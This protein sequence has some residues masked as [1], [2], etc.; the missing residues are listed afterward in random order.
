[1]PEPEALLEY[2]LQELAYEKDLSGKRVLVTAGPTREAL[3]PVRYIT[4][5]STGKMGYAIA[6]AAARRG[7]AVTLISG[8][9]ELP[10]PLGVERVDV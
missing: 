5:H 7:A 4:N 9:V 10:T 6:R 8:P 1:M 2:I 3:D